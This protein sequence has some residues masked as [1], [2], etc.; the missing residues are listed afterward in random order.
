MKP[1]LPP[2]LSISVSAFPCMFAHIST[3]FICVVTYFIIFFEISDSHGGEYEDDSL[4]VPCSF[5][6]V[7]RRFVEAVHTSE[8]SFSFSETT[9]RYIPE[10]HFF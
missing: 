5:V 8:M 3:V 1:Q 2:N 6:E 7:D 9:W 4:V 10:L